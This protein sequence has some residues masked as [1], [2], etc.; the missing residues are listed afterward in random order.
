MRYRH[1]LSGDRLEISTD[2]HLYDVKGQLA[3]EN[4]DGSYDFVADEPSKA[5]RVY[6]DSEYEDGGP[7][8][9]TESLDSLDFNGMWDLPGSREY[10]ASMGDVSG[11]KI[12]LLGNGTSAKEFLFVKL[13]A[14][15]IFTDLSFQAVVYVKRRYQKSRLGTMGLGGCEFHAVN[16]YY[17][18]FEDN[19]FDIICAD[20]SIHHLDDFNKFFAE[21]HRCLKT[22]GF[23]RFGD[24]AY[25]PLWQA[26]KKGPL[27]PLQEYI[28]MKF[29]ISPE[30]QRA[31][32]RGGFTRRELEQVKSAFGFSGLYYERVALLDYLLWRT[33]V[34][35][36]A[37]WI[38]YLRPAIRGL[39]RMLKKTSIMN[40]QG[41]TLIF[42]FDK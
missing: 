6:Y 5:E 20:A 29:P 18:P 12:L 9:G 15:V 22:G 23:C 4:H 40:S 3:F 33:R 38:L 27:R 28:H 2:G 30:D 24:T 16:A 21:V 34:K 19:V 1:P 7:W 31:T 17:L 11:K 41:I 32:N 8:A 25:S 26:A 35:F 37:G 10:F 13:G 42:G 14:H 36:N 39:D